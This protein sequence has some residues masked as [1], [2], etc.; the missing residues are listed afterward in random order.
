MGGLLCCCRA[1]SLHGQGQGHHMC[2]H[3]KTKMVQSEVKRAYYGRGQLLTT[4]DKAASSSCKDVI[5][6]KPQY[7][8]KETYR[9]LN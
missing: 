2:K 4:T 3:W 8:R 1:N 7:A 9:N 5:V 6:Y